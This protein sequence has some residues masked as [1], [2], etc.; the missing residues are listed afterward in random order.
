MV[1]L[2]GGV[3][4]CIF[5]F[6]LYNFTRKSVTLALPPFS[7]DEA[8]TKKKWEIDKNHKNAYFQGYLVAKTHFQ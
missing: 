6:F 4:F 2:E 7:L 3:E 1:D 8:P 5:W